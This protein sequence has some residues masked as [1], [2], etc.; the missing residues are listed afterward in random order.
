MCNPLPNSLSNFALQLL[1]L[2]Y[3]VFNILIK[4]NFNKEQFFFHCVKLQIHYVETQLGKL[5]Q[6]Q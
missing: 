4:I 2:L 5:I 1:Q 3:V 6:R